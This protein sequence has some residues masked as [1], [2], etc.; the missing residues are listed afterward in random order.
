MAVWLF[1][2]FIEDNGVKFVTVGSLVGS[3]SVSGPSTNSGFVIGLPPVSVP[4]SETSVTVPEVGVVAVTLAMLLTLPAFKSACVNVCTAVKVAV[5]L[6]AKVA[7]GFVPLIVALA[8]V[9]VTFDKVVLP[10]LVTTKL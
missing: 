2:I 1:T 5:A 9:T 7:I 4:V 3:V 10:V 6:G 8:S